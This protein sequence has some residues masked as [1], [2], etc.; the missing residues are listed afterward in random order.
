MFARS[1]GRWVGG[2]SAGS[3][4]RPAAV[5]FSWVPGI[6]ERRLS[7]TCLHGKVSRHAMHQSFRALVPGSSAE[8]FALT[9][10]Q[11][12][13]ENFVREFDQGSR[14]LWDLLVLFKDQ[15]VLQFVLVLLTRYYLNTGERIKAYA[16]L[17]L[18]QRHWLTGRLHERFCTV[19]GLVTLARS[20]GPCS[21]TGQ[22][23]KVFLPS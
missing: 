8:R 15:Q 9:L 12:K 14:C 16:R 13:V 4:A 18:G 23:Y 1:S 10:L 2:V 17:L 20:L 5:G 3:V 22:A 21:P 19:S 6:W 11:G 7:G